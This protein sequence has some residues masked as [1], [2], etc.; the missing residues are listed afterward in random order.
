M[1]IPEVCVF[2]LW[3]WMK[4]LSVCLSVYLIVN[5]FPHNKNPSSNDSYA[6]HC[7]P[8]VRSLGEHL[9]ESWRL[10]CF[11]PLIACLRCLHNYSPEH[12]NKQKEKRNPSF[13]AITQKW[14]MYNM[15]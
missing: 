2:P 7:F 11:H 3:E 9:K 12:F 8:Q 4:G 6:P 5:N 1:D 15:I 13:T 14:Q 10:V